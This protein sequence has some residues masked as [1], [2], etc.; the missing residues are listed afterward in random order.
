MRMGAADPR[1]G[2]VGRWVVTEVILSEGGVEGGN[3]GSTVRREVFLSEGAWR[4]ERR[5][6]GEGRCARAT[7]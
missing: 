6:Y 7:E 2:G 3:E 4:G 5:I 1:L